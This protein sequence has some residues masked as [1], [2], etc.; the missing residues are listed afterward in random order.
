V[1]KAVTIDDYIALAPEA[2]RSLL[3]RLRALCHDA[4]PHAAEQIKWGHPAYV[5]PDGV[6]LFMFSAHRAHVSFASRR[7][8]EPRSPPTSS[9]TAPVRARSRSPTTPRHPRRSSDG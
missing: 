7:P 5:H 1:T 2:G 9:A 3:E 6:I 8:L 4:A